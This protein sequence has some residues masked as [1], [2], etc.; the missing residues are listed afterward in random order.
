MDKLLT[1]SQKEIKRLEIM[2]QLKEKQMSQKQASEQMG[3]S[4]R[5]TKRIW[6]AY[7]ENGAIGLVHQH[8]GK[9]SNNRKDTATIHKACDLIYAHYR[10]FGPTLACEKLVEVHGLQISVERVRQLMISESIWKAKTRRTK[11]VFQMRQRRACFGELIQIDGSDYDW[12]EG[13]SPRCTLLVFVDDATG[14]IVEL[15]FAPHESYFAYCD[16]ARSYFE[17]Y[18]KPEA[19]YSDKHGIFH[20]N[21]PRALQGSGL[22]EFGRAMK[23]LGIQII[24]ANTPQAKGRVERANKTLQDRLTKELRLQSINNPQQAVHYLPEFIADYNRRFGVVP[25]SSTNAHC[26]LS[27]KD[28][29]DLIFTRREERTLSKNLTLQYQKVI[30][31]IQTKRPAYALQKVRVTVCENA[32]G[33]IQILYKNKPLMYTVYH[34][35]ELQ[36]E[37]VPAKSIDHALRKPYKP[38]PDHPWRKGYKTPSLEYHVP[39]QGDI[40]T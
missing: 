38:A 36:A 21:H 24:C 8:R 33:D 2:Q 7:R 23:E 34:R 3:V 16:A 5:Q 20:M 35:Q 11:R 1:M 26:P 27:R 29:L 12:F 32:L 17:R 15:Q 25:R 19:F 31:Q 9:P 28:N 14:K 18:G 40:S 6:K 22:T 4:L 37:V 30:Y 10:D 13:R 39:N